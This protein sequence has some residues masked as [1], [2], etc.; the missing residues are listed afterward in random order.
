MQSSSQFLDQ[1]AVTWNKATLQF[2]LHGYIHIATKKLF[3]LAEYNKQDS[4]NSESSQS[5][6]RRQ[7]NSEGLI[8][9][10]KVNCQKVYCGAS[11]TLSP[12]AFPGTFDGKSM[13]TGPSF[14]QSS[15]CPLSPAQM[16]Q[17]FC[18]FWPPPPLPSVSQPAV[19]ECFGHKVKKDSPIHHNL[20]ST[21]GSQ[22]QSQSCRFANPASVQAWNFKDLLP[23]AKISPYLL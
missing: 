4:L 2:I 8:S 15:K 5:K 7:L 1:Q 10:S 6:S 9:Y 20:P 12:T 19:L 14:K 16:C 23:Q 21:T 13:H 3:C 18:I 11:A 17:A 22:S